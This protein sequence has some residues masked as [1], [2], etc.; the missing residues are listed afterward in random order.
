MHGQED[1]ENGAEARTRKASNR[2]PE[3]SPSAGPSVAR[4]L[5]PRLLKFPVRPRLAQPTK[6][7]GR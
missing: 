6:P 7:N 4:P 5:S 1:G 2:I 3:G